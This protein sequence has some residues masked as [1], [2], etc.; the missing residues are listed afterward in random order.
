MLHADPELL[1]IKLKGV[2]ENTH[3]VKTL[4]TIYIKNDKK[5]NL[6]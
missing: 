1:K 3:D 2:D 4:Y 6:S 5:I